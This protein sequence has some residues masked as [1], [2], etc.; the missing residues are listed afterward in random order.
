MATGV[1]FLNDTDV[2]A[3]SGLGLKVS[4]IDGHRE[5]PGRTVRAAP[6]PGRDGHIELSTSTTSPPRVIRVS[7]MQV[8]SSLADLMTKLDAL[9]WL[10]TGLVRVRVGD[11]SDREFVGRIKLT[12]GVLGAWMQGVAHSVQIE[13]E[14]PDPLARGLS[15]QVVGFS[16][17]ATQIPLGTAPSRPVIRIGN[18]T[19]PVITYRD[20]ASAQIAQM[21]FTISLGAAEWIDIDCLNQTIVDDQAANQAAALNAA[22][23]FI[24]LDPRDAAAVDGPWPTIETSSGTVATCTYRKRY[25]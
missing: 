2:D 1:L 23:S 18:A 24:A 16:G 6:V 4:R 12:V 3:A 9:K 10:A 17:G 11:A 22:D 20:A 19:N 5:S 13:A 21:R 25:L 7:A 15:D 8:G 14:C